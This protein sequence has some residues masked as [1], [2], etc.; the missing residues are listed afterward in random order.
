[1]T[2][3][4]RIVAVIPARLASVRMPGK[5]LASETGMPMVQHVV[6]AAKQASRLT[7]VVVATE[8]EEVRSA[9]APFG[10]TV[11]MSSPEHPNGTSRL[12]EAADIL[13]LGDDDI[14]V[15]VQGDE[16]EM[17]GSAIDA[18]IAALIASPGAVVATVAS[19]FAEHEDPNNP[20]MV[21]AILGVGGNALYFTRALAPYDRDG[22][23]AQRVG[24][25]SAPLK[26]VGLY[27]YRRSFLP[28]YRTLAETPLELTE[29]LEQLRIL[30]HGY[31]IACA[32]QRVDSSGIDTP[33]QYAAFVQRYRESLQRG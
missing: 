17:D 23:A 6:D 1:M 28:I 4:T 30:E 11:L 9:L 16:P 27:A 10:T 31:S 22:D 20:N 15:N 33:E 25:A 24:A 8:S 12:A 13:G 5:V 26:H 19:P 14:A 3:P 21:K 2:T 32:V 7:E 18:S 29:R